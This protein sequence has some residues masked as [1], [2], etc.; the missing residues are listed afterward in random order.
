MPYSRK[1][2]SVKNLAN[3][4]VLPPSVKILSTNFC[5]RGLGE[6]M[7]GVNCKRA[8]DRSWFAARVCRDPL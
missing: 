5:A 1:L 6:R 8:H 4:A 2:S 7:G 3:F